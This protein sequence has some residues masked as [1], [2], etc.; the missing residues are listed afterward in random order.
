MATRIEQLT[1]ALQSALGERAASITV[2]LGEATLVVKAADILAVMQTLRDH[3][4][5]KFEELIDVC[6]DGGKDLLHDIRG[7]GRLQTRSTAPT[8]DGRS[9]DRR[10]AAPGFGIAIPN[11]LQQR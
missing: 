2:A 5:F 11:R 10:K 6:G 4:D 7:V 3:P 1:S 8:I 9:V